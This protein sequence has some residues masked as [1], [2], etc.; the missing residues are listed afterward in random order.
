MKIVTVIPFIKGVFK[1][2]LTYFTS[3]DIQNGSIVSIQVRNKNI[4][5]LVINSEEVKNEKGNIKDLPFNLKKIIETKEQVIFRTEFLDS[6]LEISKYFVAKK[7]DGASA[8]IPSAFKEEYDQIAKFNNA[9]LNY[10]NENKEIFKN[11]KNEKLLFQAP[12]VDRISYYKTL[13]RGSF[14]AKKSVFIV[15]PNKHEI[16]AFFE[17][18]AKGIEKFVF[19]IHGELNT[20]KQIE[21]AR[22]KLIEANG[23]LQI[24]KSDIRSH[25]PIFYICKK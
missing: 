7:S 14:A 4:L 9:T 16:E 22:L 11:L 20:K 21:E 15:L 19:S 25:P 24:S 23:T 2:D 5:G 13:I 18:L 10:K 8:L 6:I 17:P 3:K 1:E 12:L